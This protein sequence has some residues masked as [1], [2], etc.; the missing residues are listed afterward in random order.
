MRNNTLL[1][2]WGDMKVDGRMAS[3]CQQAAW[4]AARKSRR[5]VFEPQAVTKPAK[6]IGK[7]HVDI[8]SQDMTI[9][10]Q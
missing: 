3:F 9:Y 1:S 6:I 5:K 10:E 7:G 8:V 4:S 2:I